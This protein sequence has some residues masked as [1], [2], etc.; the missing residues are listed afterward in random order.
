M[1]QHLMKWIE[2]NLEHHLALQSED[3][4]VELLSLAAEI[5][6]RS[7]EQ[8]AEAGAHAQTIVSH[9]QEE[10][11]IVERLL[12]ESEAARISAEMDLKK[13]QAKLEETESVFEARIALLQQEKSALQVCADAAERRA[14]TVEES[15]ARLKTGLGS[16]FK[17]YGQQVGT[18][19]RIA[20][21]S[22]APF[23]QG[24]ESL[25]P[26]EPQSHAKG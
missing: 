14:K 17:R 23:E 6:R 19:Q 18:D 11:K 22:T 16:L 8:L 24:R 13:A 4:D 9:A 26:Q 20:S 15:L 1:E 25:F 10:L 2:K 12:Q 3:D 21:P 5:M 7:Q